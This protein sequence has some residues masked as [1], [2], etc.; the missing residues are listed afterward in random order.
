M[1][2]PRTGLTDTYPRGWESYTLVQRI[3][4]AQLGA[5]GAHVRITVQASAATDA[6]V[7]RI[8]ISQQDAAG[9]P[10]DS[11][12]DLT[13]VYDSAANQQQPFVVPA[14]MKR[15]LPIV[16]YTITRF[17]ALL[18]AVDFS[19]APASG[20]EFAPSVPMS[21][22]SAYFFLSGLEAGVRIRSP[23]Y[24]FIGDIAAMTSAVVFITRIEVG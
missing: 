20:A 14:G 5:T 2:I 18:I 19:S 3:E 1:G 11:A 23:N 7:E 10:Y 12:A 16:T 9:K 13:A 6:S 21:E 22:A 17:Q 15:S 4:A 24:T 8:Y